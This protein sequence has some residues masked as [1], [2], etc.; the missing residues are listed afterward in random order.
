[1]DPACDL[2]YIL[3]IFLLDHEK[4]QRK[5]PDSNDHIEDR[6]DRTHLKDL[7]DQQIRVSGLVQVRQKEVHIHDEERVH[8]TCDQGTVTDVHRDL[9]VK[10]S[11]PI[12]FQFCILPP[13]P[14]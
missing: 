7:Q 9:P 2:P 11:A 5:D 13:R 14:L 10:A 1:M 4:R 6:G 12:I 3:H 8:Q